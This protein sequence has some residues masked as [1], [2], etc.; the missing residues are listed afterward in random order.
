MRQTSWELSLI[1]SQSAQSTALCR[2]TA[3]SSIFSIAS[4]GTASYGESLSIQMQ[5]LA[6]VMF[7][8]CE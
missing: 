4:M 3:L 8:L 7:L 2:Q 1:T 6:S 5:K